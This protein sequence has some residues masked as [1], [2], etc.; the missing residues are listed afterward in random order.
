MTFFAIGILFGALLITVGLYEDI[1]SEFLSIKLSFTA[2]LLNGF[3][4]REL[5]FSR[6]ECA[7]FF[8]FDFPISG[9]RIN[10]FSF[11]AFL[12]KVFF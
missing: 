12:S 1:Y 6:T 3:L 8:S 11:T 2:M 5:L 9:F 10:G 7:I 4:I